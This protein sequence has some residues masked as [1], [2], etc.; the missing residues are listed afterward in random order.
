MRWVAIIAVCLVVLPA[1]ASGA[2]TVGSFAKK[3]DTSDWLRAPPGSTLEVRWTFDLTRAAPPVRGGTLDDLTTHRVPLELTLTLNGHS[4]AVSLVTDAAPAYSDACS[5]VSFFYAGINILFQL[6]R[7]NRGRALLT[8]TQ[9]SES[10]PT[11]TR[12]LYVF[13]L[14]AGVHVAQE[15][16]TI[17]PSGRQASITCTAPSLP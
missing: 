3:L 2:T 8:W 9:T 17:D 6:E 13:D 15:I 14:P 1:A 16:V 11:K 5:R 10:A 12:Q 4:H 7:A